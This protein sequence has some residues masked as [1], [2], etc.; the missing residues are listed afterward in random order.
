MFYFFVYVVF[1]AI[2]ISC[3]LPIAQ[4]NSI[5]YLDVLTDYLAFTTFSGVMCGVIL[6]FARF[7]TKIKFNPNARIFRIPKFEQRFYEEIKIDK[8]KCLVPDFGKMVGFKKKIDP[9]QA[10]SSQFYRRFLYENINASLLHFIDILLTPFFFFFLHPEFYI[11]IGLCGMLI[12]F[13]LNIIPVMLQR[14]LRPRLL[15]LYNKLLARE[16]AMSKS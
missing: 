13:F 1:S 15:N 14:Y 11:T 3:S 8:W 9:S 5:P 2:A 4:Q 16:N 10:K 7:A 6:L 12:I